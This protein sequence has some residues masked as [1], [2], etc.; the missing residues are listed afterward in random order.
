MTL[1]QKNQFLINFER[2]FKCDKCEARF[3]FHKYLRNH[4]KEVHA[5]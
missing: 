1:E 5:Y 4:K 2:P 3:K